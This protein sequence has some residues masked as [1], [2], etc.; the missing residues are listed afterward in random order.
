[1]QQ[2]RRLFSKKKVHL[3]TSS[4]AN[5]LQINVRYFIAHWVFGKAALFNNKQN[6]VTADVNNGQNLLF[7]SE[8]EL[9]V[10]LIVDHYPS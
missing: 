3:Q 10:W 9:N 6:V 2:Q 7:T 4:Q 5:F 8:P 1:M